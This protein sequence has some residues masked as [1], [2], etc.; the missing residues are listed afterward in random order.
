MTHELLTGLI[1]MALLAQLQ[2]PPKPQDALAGPYRQLFSVQPVL[3][4]EQ[5]TVRPSPRVV[6]TTSRLERGPC[7]MPIIVAKP[8]VDPKMIV[9]VA[10]NNNTDPKIRVIEPPVC[11]PKR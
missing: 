3:P 4:A 6:E 9:P 11:G 7:N 2:S 1:A 10:K 8:A 5:V